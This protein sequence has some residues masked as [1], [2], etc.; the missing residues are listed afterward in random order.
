MDGHA[1][2]FGAH[3]PNDPQ[4]PIVTIFGGVLPLGDLRLQTAAVGQD[5]HCR[6][7]HLLRLGVIALRVLGTRADCHALHAAWFEDAAAPDVVRVLE[8]AGDDVGD[9][10]HVAMRL[11]RPDAPGASVS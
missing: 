3:R 6:K 1:H 4:P 10:L 8:M 7:L 2:T 9:A 5:P 11:H